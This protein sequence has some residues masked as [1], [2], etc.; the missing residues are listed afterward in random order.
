MSTGCVSANGVTTFALASPSGTIYTVEIPAPED[1]GEGWGVEVVRDES[2]PKIIVK[3]WMGWRWKDTKRNTHILTIVMLCL[4]LYQLRPHYQVCQSAQS[5]KNPLWCT[6]C[7]APSFQWREPLNQRMLLPAWLYISLRGRWWFSLFARTS[8]CDCGHTRWGGDVKW[9]VM[10]L[11]CEKW[12]D[13]LSLS[14]SI[15]LSQL[16]QCVMTHK[17]SDYIQVEDD[18]ALKGTYRYTV[19]ISEL[20]R[21]QTH[22]EVQSYIPPR[23]VYF[24]IIIVLV[25]NTKCV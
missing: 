3:G 8:N 17:L 14:L 5:C 22:C 19:S 24:L 13:S 15:S 16:K 21:Q 10:W 11:A 12:S 4:I 7:W 18:P 25:R 1:H 2:W 23:V 6:D 9:L 20:C